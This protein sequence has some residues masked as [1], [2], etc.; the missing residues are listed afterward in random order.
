MKRTSLL[1]NRTNCTFASHRPGQVLK[2]IL[3]YDI[4]FQFAFH[5]SV[6]V[7]LTRNVNVS[8]ANKI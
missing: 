8:C 6:E 7:R 4:S 1:R 3:I 5:A 2:F